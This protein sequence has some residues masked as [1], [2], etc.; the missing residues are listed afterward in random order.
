MFRSY[1]LYN[2][3]I[4]NALFLKRK[5]ILFAPSHSPEPPR[6]TY[7]YIYI[8][9]MLYTIHVYRTLTIRRVRISMNT[10][11]RAAFATEK[12]LTYPCCEHYC[13][14]GG[15]G[16]RDHWRKDCSSYTRLNY[17]IWFSYCCAVY[18]LSA[19]ITSVEILLHSSR[20]YETGR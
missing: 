19:A 18:F 17:R 4:A 16:W 15:P 12:V 11:G 3:N 6:V 1:I 7:T 13:G 5:R 8:L 10:H 9:C 14:L 2:N 20:I